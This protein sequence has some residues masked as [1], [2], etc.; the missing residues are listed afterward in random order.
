[1]KLIRVIPEFGLPYYRTEDG[2]FNATKRASHTREPWWDL[3]DAKTGKTYDLELL[4]EV[5]ETIAELY[6]ESKP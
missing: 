3:R 5:K 1:M 2:R 6:E 4:R